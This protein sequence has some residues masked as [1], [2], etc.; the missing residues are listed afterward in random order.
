M[1][2]TI[3]ICEPIP[4]GI[5]TGVYTAYE[6][7]L[8]PND[9]HIQLGEEENYRLFSEYV[10][11]E[12]DREKAEKVDRSLRKRLGNY[13]VECLWYAMASADKSRG[14]AVYHTVA[15]GLAGAYKGELMDYLQD[16]YVNLTAKLRINVWQEAHR[17]QG[18]VRFSELESGILYSEIE[19]KNDI[20][21]F[22]GEHF[23]DR[24][25]GEHFLIRDKKRNLYLIHQ[26]GRGYFLY[27][28]EAGRE[29]TEVT[30]QKKQGR[31]NWSVHGGEQQ[32]RVT[33]PVEEGQQPSLTYSSEE[34]KIQE[35]F[36]CFL[37][38]VSIKERENKKLQ[39]QMLPL[40]FRGNMVDF[41]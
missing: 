37:H 11:V 14:D 29:R 12:T 7:K 40:R 3:L 17:F 8:S 2:E 15:R 39:Q 19:P 24:F 23:S 34:K 18:F 6:Q 16:P 26:A 30:E 28:Q 25:P 13:T 22:L 27:Q 10:Q 35:L 41:F 9:T 5:L 1:T 32:P 36:R 31:E 38:S 21:P 33:Y 20:L 4:E